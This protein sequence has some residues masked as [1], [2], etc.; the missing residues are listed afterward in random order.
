MNGDR[1]GTEGRRGQSSLLGWARSV[2][3]LTSV[4]GSVGLVDLGRRGQR[5]TEGMELDCLPC[6]LR[7]ASSR[8]ESFSLLQLFRLLT[9][10]IGVLFTWIQNQTGSAWGGEWTLGLKAAF[11]TN[12]GCHIVGVGD[13]APGDGG[14][15]S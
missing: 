15:F 10:S 11:R 5:S 12:V 3:V 13:R 8:L 6:L 4:S 1:E 2:C 9:S 7:D 14:W